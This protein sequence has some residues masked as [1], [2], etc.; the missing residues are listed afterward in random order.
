M[1]SIESSTLLLPRDMRRAIRNTVMSNQD[2]AGMPVAP[3][4]ASTLNK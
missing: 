4:P 2:E 1:P 3:S